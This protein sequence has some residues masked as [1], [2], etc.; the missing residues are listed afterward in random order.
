MLEAV[1]AL[2]LSVLVIAVFG[3]F[4]GRWLDHNLGP[5]NALRIEIFMT[6]LGLTALLGMAPDRILYLCDG[7][8]AAAPDAGS[9]GDPPPEVL[10]IGCQRPSSS[11][12]TG[13][14]V[15]P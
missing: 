7:R 6:I 3:G 9:L 4:V 15:T 8:F 1:I 2:L 5:K 10:P 11:R 14:L 13:R 12:P